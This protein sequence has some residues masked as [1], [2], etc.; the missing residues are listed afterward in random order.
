MDE[1]APSLLD[2]VRGSVMAG[3]VVGLRNSNRRPKVLSVQP[4]GSLHHDSSAVMC[5]PH[6]VQ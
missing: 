4:V 5:V 1:S 6:G 2:G 3:A